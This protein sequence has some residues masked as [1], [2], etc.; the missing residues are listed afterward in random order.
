MPS[1]ARPLLLRSLSV[2]AALL[3]VA[4]AATTLHIDCGSASDA[5]Y[6]GGAPWPMPIP[7]PGTNDVTVRWGT[8]FAYHIPVDPG[9]YTVS[10]RFREPDGVAALPKRIFQVNGQT[11]TS[12][13]LSLSMTGA[14]VDL[15]LTT[16]VRSA[17]LSSIDVAP[18]A[19][20]IPTL[21]LSDGTIVDL[22]PK[23]LVLDRT[24]TRTTL[25][26]TPHPRQRTVSINYFGSPFNLPD[27]PLPG[28]PVQ[29]MWGGLSGI[30]GQDWSLSGNT[31]TFYGQGWSLGDAL[32]ITYFF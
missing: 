14:S 21:T 32:V 6:T 20:G 23:T 18:V 1:P 7:P 13:V 27:T 5:Y 29:I 19:A 4:Q 8:S 22:D 31:V 9:T 12:D 28:T 3:S 25:R 24:G 15:S 16:T 17:I 10:L 2:A 26:A 11:V 30:P